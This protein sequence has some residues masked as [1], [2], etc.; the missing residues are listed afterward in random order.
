LLLDP[1]PM[2]ERAA[3]EP[4]VRPDSLVQIRDRDADVVDPP[5]FHAGDAIR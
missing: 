2:L 3:E 1:L 5:C 4:L